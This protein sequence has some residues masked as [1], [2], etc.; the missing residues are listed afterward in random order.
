VKRILLLP[1]VFLF[2]FLC[3]AVAFSAL[4]FFDSW[5]RSWDGAEK[6]T[7]ETAIRQMPSSLLGVLVP[8]VLIGLLAIGM[9]STRIP[10]HR[11]V[12]FPVALIL[13]YALTVGGFLG[14]EI[15]ERGTAAADAASERPLPVRSF[16]QIG[17]ASLSAEKVDGAELR[18]VLL[19][20]PDA[21]GARFRVYPSAVV[22][23]TGDLLRVRAGKAGTA[24]AEG[25]VESA[26]DGIFRADPVT[27]AFLSDLGVLG[28]DFRRLRSS[29]FPEFLVAVF[30]LL[31]ALTAS[32][33]F[34]RLTRWPLANLLLYVLA[35]RGSF[36]LFRLLREGLGA[37]IAAVFTD[38]LLVRLFPYGVFV[39]I[40][41]LLLLVDL[42]FVPADRLREEAA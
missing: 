2:A 35:V 23:R 21:K 22:E 25:R 38:P 24:V 19:Y 13:S 28:G 30:A 20:S 27:A 36:L 29:S 31:F 15:L 8:S 3:A 14:L 16:T 33:V 4:C 32:F 39:A 9:R 41:L 1:V 37:R 26:A 6:P 5:G 18:G 40:G 17:S 12:L 10:V 34:L 11:L 7:A 42:L